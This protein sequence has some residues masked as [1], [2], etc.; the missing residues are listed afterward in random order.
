MLE[1]NER[2][3]ESIFELVKC[4]TFPFTV[5]DFMQRHRLAHADTVYMAFYALADKGKVR[6][7][8]SQ[9]NENHRDST[10]I[11]LP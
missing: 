2:A 4:E 10:K 5:A 11:C 9:G 7:E 3:M 1:Q 8:R 6:I